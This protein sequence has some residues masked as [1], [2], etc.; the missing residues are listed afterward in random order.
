MTTRWRSPGPNDRGQ[1]GHFHAR[2]CGRGESTGMPLGLSLTQELLG[3]NEPKTF[4]LRPGKHFFLD[5]RVV[6]IMAM[7]ECTSISSDISVG[8]VG[9]CIIVYPRLRS[10]VGVPSIT[11]HDRSS[12]MSREMCKLLEGEESYCQLAGLREAPKVRLRVQQFSQSSQCKQHISRE[13]WALQSNFLPNNVDC[14][15][16][17]NMQSRF[18]IRWTEFRPHDVM[19][20]MAIMVSRSF[21]MVSP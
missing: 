14:S 20:V 2:G 7:W 5:D 13:S 12:L 11:K 18:L 9:F 16:L 6:G 21:H 17:F 3:R 10:A 8:G 1:G 4:F 15:W 19:A